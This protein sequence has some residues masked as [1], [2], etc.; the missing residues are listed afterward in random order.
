MPKDL[1]Q[2][3][4]PTTILFNA[5]LIINTTDIL[6][7][8]QFIVK[9]INIYYTQV[10]IHVYFKTSHLIQTA[11]GLFLLFLKSMLSL[12]FL[13]HSNTDKLSSNTIWQN[14]ISSMD[15]ESS[16]FF[17]FPVI[18]ELYANVITRHELPEWLQSE[19]YSVKRNGAST[20]PCGGSVL[21]C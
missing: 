18:S 9:Y 7:S 21:N 20:V 8:T 5:F 3:S 11:L 14:C 2:F 16:S 12:L 13:K 17:L 10:L 19:G 15:T 6:V 1:S 4:Q